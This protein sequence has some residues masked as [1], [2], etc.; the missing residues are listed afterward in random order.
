MPKTK[1]KPIIFDA[2]VLWKHVGQP[3]YGYSI[4]IDKDFGL[5]AGDQVRVT[6][7]KVEKK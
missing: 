4:S 7:E 1:E 3:E 6:I 2:Y 5:Q